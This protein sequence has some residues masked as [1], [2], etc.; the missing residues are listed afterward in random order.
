MFISVLSVR[1]ASVFQWFS[2][3]RHSANCRQEV[4]SL[5]H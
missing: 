2:P 4:E 3:S 5:N 1:F